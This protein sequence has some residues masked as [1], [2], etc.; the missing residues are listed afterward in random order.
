MHRVS[1]PPGPVT[2]TPVREVSLCPNILLPRPRPPRPNAPMAHHCSVT[3]QPPGTGRFAAN[4]T[5][6]AAAPT[7][8]RWLYQQAA[9]LH[10]GR[11]PRN[12]DADAL[13]V[14]RLCEKLLTAKLHQRDGGELSPSMCADCGEV[15]KRLQRVFGKSRLVNDLG[16]DD[17]AR[18]AT[19]GR[20]L[21]STEPWSV[22]SGAD[23]T[24]RQRCRCGL[25]NPAKPVGPPAGPAV[26]EGA[27]LTVLV[28]AGPQVGRVRPHLV[29]RNG[30]VVTLRGVPG[31]T[32]RQTECGVSWRTGARPVAP[33]G[34]PVTRGL[35]VQ[36]LM[37]ARRSALI[38]SACVVHIPCGNFS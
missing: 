24:R 27:A 36:P 4:S 14:R 34:A 19:L 22:R 20:A 9:D 15:C 28:M 30:V 33:A 13:T 1:L 29:D 17:F 21:V 3:S 37:K 32:P 12:G 16:P 35:P 5:T 6:A 10:A 25:R 11:K 31:R 18:A 23:L 7:L 26:H 38:T 8:R 2:V